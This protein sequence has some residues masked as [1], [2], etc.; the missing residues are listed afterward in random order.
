MV[1]AEVLMRWQHAT[2]GLIRPD[3]FIPRRKSLA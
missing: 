2:E 3:L 1:G